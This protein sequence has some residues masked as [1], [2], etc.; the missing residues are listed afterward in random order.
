M[1]VED[2]TSDMTEFEDGEEIRIYFRT[3][4]SAPASYIEGPIEVRNN[5][6]KVGI[7]RENGDIV[8]ADFSRSTEGEN[9]YELESDEVLGRAMFAEPAEIEP[10]ERGIKEGG[11]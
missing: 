4:S 7:K 1:S 6:E 5:D 3:S 9:L 2:R 11:R 10:M 8:I